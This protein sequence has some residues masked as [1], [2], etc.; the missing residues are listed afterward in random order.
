MATRRN[1]LGSA[2]LAALLLVPVAR[3]LAD[4][5]A[6]G[7][8]DI[9]FALT[10]PNVPI[11]G[12]ITFD[13]GARTALGQ[14]IDMSASVGDMTFEGTA[15][16]N[17]LSESA[18]FTLGPSRTATSSSPRRGRGV[19]T[20]RAA[21]AARALSPG[22]SIRSPTLGTSSPT[23]S[24]P[25]TGRRRPTADLRVARAAPSPSTPSR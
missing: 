3:V 2:L 15:F 16:V 13:P 17:I 9:D 23:A 18:T 6:T 11:N 21:R 24:S 10:P 22:A 19:V 8:F 4:V 1:A 5:A 12:E 25:S 20:T 14:S 7:T